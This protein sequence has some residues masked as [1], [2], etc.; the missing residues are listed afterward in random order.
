MICGMLFIRI[1]NEINS[2]GGDLV[3][4]AYDWFISSTGLIEFKREGKNEK[5]HASN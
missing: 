3:G 2:I 1:I 4:E 5:N